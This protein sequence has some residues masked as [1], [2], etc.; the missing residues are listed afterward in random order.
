MS[1]VTRLEEVLTLA[2]DG[3]VVLDARADDT[4][5]DVHPHVGAFVDVSGDQVSRSHRLLHEGDRAP[6]ELGRHDETQIV[7]TDVKATHRT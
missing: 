7:R 1:D 6:G 5:E 3:F 2:R 4:V